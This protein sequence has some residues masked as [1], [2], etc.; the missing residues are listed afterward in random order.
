MAKLALRHCTALNKGTKPLRPAVAKPLFAQ[1]D[2]G[3]QLAENTI[4]RQF[5]FNGFQHMMSF[6]NA[7]AWI[8]NH[9]NHHPELELNQKQCKVRL[10]SHIA[11]GLTVNDFICAAKID[12]LF[13]S[14]LAESTQ[15][16]RKPKTQSKPIT[17]DSEPALTFN[18]EEADALLKAP[19]QTE[20]PVKAHSDDDEDE[21]ELIETEK[22]ASFAPQQAKSATPDTHAIKPKVQP[23]VETKP[24]ELEPV[25]EEPDDMM[26][27]MIIPPAEA[28]A[29]AQRVMMEKGEEPALMMP[30][31]NVV[32][33]DE[34]TEF[35]KTLITAPDNIQPENNKSNSY[36]ESTEPLPPGGNDPDEVRTVILASNEISNS[37]TPVTPPAPTVNQANTPSKTNEHD[38]EKTM[39]LSSDPTGSIRNAQSSN[40]I[41]PADPGIDDDETLVMHV[42]TY[43]SILK[44]KSDE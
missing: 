9:E 16:T 38:V 41:E 4:I 33:N 42:N 10:S 40:E 35:E 11:N 28:A 19:S 1:I 8:A 37:P 3:W 20:T 22:T 25:E 5:E 44:K 30:N 6:V 43:K 18:P 26:A 23:P 15:G 12:A 13:P 32:I 39:V 27:T 36:G 17:N 14:K 21:F 34:E 24:K 31:V 7:V 29:I 2:P